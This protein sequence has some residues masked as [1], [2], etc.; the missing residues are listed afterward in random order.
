MRGRR[1]LPGFNVPVAKPE[2][3]GPEANPW[4]WHP[5]RPQSKVAD[6]RF[7]DDLAKV[8]P[9]L[10]VS[11]NP[12]RGN[13]QVFTKAPNFSHPICT[14]WKLLFIHHDGD[15][16]YLPLDNRIMARL[17]SADLSRWPSAK[18]YFDQVDSEVRRQKAKQ[19]ERLKQEA[20]D[21]AMPFW[22]HS[23]IKNIGKGSKFSTY[24]A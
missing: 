14:G 3:V 21:Q 8:D 20:I 11:W 17:Y 6:E 22:E 4:F 5:D 24:H 7:V 2:K 16:G 23:Q 19:E 18:A 10:A 1:K 15:G 12:V 9:K 13:W